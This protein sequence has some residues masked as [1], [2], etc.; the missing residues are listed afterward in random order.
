MSSTNTVHTITSLLWPTGAPNMPFDQITAYRG[1]GIVQLEKS[2]LYVFTCKIHPYMFG[3][4]I[5]DDPTTVGLDLGEQLSLSTGAELDPIDETGKA[6]IDAIG[7][8]LALL[9]TFFVANNPSNWIDYNLPTWNPKFPSVDI[10]FG[11][12]VDNL[13][14]LLLDTVGGSDTIDLNELR[15][16]ELKTPEE[17]GE[18]KGV[19]E[20]WV[21]TQFEKTAHKSKPGTAT[22]VNVEDW[23][24]ERKVSLPE[25]NMNNPHN[26]W[27]DREQKIIYQTQ[28]FDNL[29]TAFDR[30]TGQ[31][32]DNI[33]IGDAPSHV[34]TNP[35]DDLL[36]VALSGEQGVAELKF[37]KENNKF[38]MQRIIPL[39]DSG[40][41]PTH[42]HAFWISSDGSKMITPNRFTDDVTIYD[43]NKYTANSQD[44]EA[45]KIQSKT[46]TAKMPIATGM[47]PDGKTAYV[48]NFLSGTI[49]VVN[50]DSGK[51]IDEIDLPSYGH[52]LPIQTPVSPNGEYV[53][54]ANTLTGSIAIIDTQT[55]EIV[56]SLPCDPGCHGVN[57]GAK[58]GGGYY[59]YVSSKFSNRLIVVDGDP[60]NDGNPVD[61]KIAGSVLLTGYYDDMDKPL[62]G[63]DDEI[64]QYYG[65]GGQGVYA[66]PNVYPGW[67]Y[68]L[69]TTWNLTPEQRD[70]LNAFYNDQ[71][72]QQLQQQELQLQSV[73]PMQSSNDDVATGTDNGANI[74]SMKHQQQERTTP[75]SLA[76]KITQLQQQTVNQA[77]TPNLKV[78]DEQ[79]NPLSSFNNQQLQS[80]QPMQSSNN[81]VATATDNGDNVATMQQQ[82]KETTTSQSIEEKLAQIQQQAINQEIA[83]KTIEENVNPSLEK[84]GNI[85]SMLPIPYP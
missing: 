85:I 70:P 1:G 64:T 3:G 35:T 77:M 61:A 4:V 68:N 6:N 71:E 5:V 62:F 82:Q 14:D 24:V 55:D 12:L 48:A 63:T 40:Q 69:D 43:Y 65:M 39:Q 30:E 44:G 19:G 8:A 83:P 58:E 41:F 13:Q 37:N 75:E 38:E 47:M 26:M 42:P 57:F 7:T 72:Q 54:T 33:R 76:D 46:Y 56:Q 45:G 15:G 84:V 53:V 9:R 66:I 73:Q 17:N 60:N 11:G 81:N 31:L 10:N 2:G 49:S 23:N 28:W 29:L 80:V 67:V 18:E 59:A 16:T 51:V 79:H 34:M 36:Y 50:M 25:I 27:S 32:L 20:V 74:D 78:N 52:A 21:D 22:R